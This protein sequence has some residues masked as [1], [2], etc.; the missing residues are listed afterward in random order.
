[1]GQSST[2]LDAEAEVQPLLQ[3]DPEDSHHHGCFP[4]HRLED[5]CPAN[6]WVDLPVYTTIHR[7]SF[8]PWS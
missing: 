6:P 4:P 5:V 7:Y 1:M 3:H 2:R 8:L